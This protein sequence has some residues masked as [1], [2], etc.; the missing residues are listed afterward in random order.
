MTNTLKAKARKIF[1]ILNNKYSE[2]DCTLDYKNPFQLLVATI[3][4]AQST[5]KNVNK[6]TPQLFNKYPDPKSFADA[7]IEELQ[8]YIFS[9]GFYRQK[10]R[11]I[12]EASQDIVNEYD[13][14]VPDSIDALTKLRGVG[15]KTANVVLGTSFNKPAIIVDTHML[16]V[17]GRLGLIPYEISAKK[18]AVKAEKELMDI[19]DKENWTQ[20]SHMIVYFGR[21]ICNAKK[22]KHDIC[23]L[24]DLCEYGKQELQ[25]N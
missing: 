9:T 25:N 14:I 15:R 13:G 22:P 3:L 6:V 4:A 2:A 24:L 23:P 21:D 16:R 1:D 7:D 10:A 12:I 18:D 19:I 11:S 20:F 17:T 8:K 5:D